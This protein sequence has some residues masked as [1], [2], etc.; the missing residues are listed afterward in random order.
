MFPETEQ[1]TAF[2]VTPF[3]GS[4]VALPCPTP[5][6]AAADR[7]RSMCPAEFVQVAHSSTIVAVRVL[8]AY[9]TSTHIRQS[10]PC[11]NVPIGKAAKDDVGAFGTVAVIPGPQCHH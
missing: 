2:Q 11:P 8:P 3:I 4:P 10:L 5:R 9:E 1:A 6:A 7:L